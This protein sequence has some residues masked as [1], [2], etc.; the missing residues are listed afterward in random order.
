MFVTEGIGQWNEVLRSSASKNTDCLSYL[1]YLTGFISM[2]D[3][4]KWVLV[5]SCAYP[6]RHPFVVT[7]HHR[8]LKGVTS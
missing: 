1:L 7:P 2:G 3:A 8:S 5:S 4:P 6:A